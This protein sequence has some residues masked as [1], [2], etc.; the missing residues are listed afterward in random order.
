MPDSLP[1]NTFILCSICATTPHFLLLRC[2]DDPILS[3]SHMNI[4]KDVLEFSTY[5]SFPDEARLV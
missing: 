3:S 2:N 5:G 1:I 4:N